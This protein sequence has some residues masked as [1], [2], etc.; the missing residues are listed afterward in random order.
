[1][2]PKAHFEE[3]AT[4]TNMNRMETI[5]SATKLALCQWCET[6]F[7]P[8]A[9]GG[10]IKK[11]CSAQCRNLYHAAARKW[12]QRAVSVGLLSIADLKVA[13]ASCTTQE[14]ASKA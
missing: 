14:R 12:V 2:T 6:P 7:L 1:M 8:K 3:K 9:V 13:Q 11:F 4:D 5:Q 10:H